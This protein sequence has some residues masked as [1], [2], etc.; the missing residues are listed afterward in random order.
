MNRDRIRSGRA[1]A[2]SKVIKLLTAGACAA[3]ATVPLAANA[4]TTSIP[5]VH[6]SSLSPTQIAQLAAKPDQRVIVILKNQENGVTGSHGTLESSRGAA[7]VGSELDPQRAAPPQGTEYP[8][9]FADQRGLDDRLG[10]RGVA[11]RREPS[12]RRGHPG[13]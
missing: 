13:H 11:S 4:Q 8:W 5:R 1:F 3:L 9:L 6:P 2:G 10:S 7:P 12:G